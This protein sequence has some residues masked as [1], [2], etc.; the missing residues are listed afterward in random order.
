MSVKKLDSKHWAAYFEQFS[1]ELIGEKRVDYA[2]IRVFSRDFGA[3]RETSWLPLDG[4]TYDAKDDVLEV[5]VKGLDHLVYKPREI[6]I[7]E[8]REG[9]LTSLEVVHPD[10]T[11]E[12]IELR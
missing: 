8:T 7:D 11:T 12:V 4:I 3:Q 6:Y 2:E 1:K 5:A 10:G 9:I